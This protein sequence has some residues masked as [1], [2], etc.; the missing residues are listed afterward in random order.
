[1]LAPALQSVDQ[2]RRQDDDSELRARIAPGLCADARAHGRTV[3]MLQSEVVE[4]ARRV[5]EVRPRSYSAESL[6]NRTGAID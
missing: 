6:F 3:V 5:R 4:W 2:L 1:V